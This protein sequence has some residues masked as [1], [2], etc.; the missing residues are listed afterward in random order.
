M[1]FNNANAWRL[2]PR[3]VKITRNTQATVFSEDA[4]SKTDPEGAVSAFVQSVTAS[5][6]R[7]AGRRVALG[8]MG[9]D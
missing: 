9:R 4:R 8:W 1:R 2:T 3:I 7:M 6:V 5:K